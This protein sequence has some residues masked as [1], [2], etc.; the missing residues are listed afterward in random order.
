M[1][2]F[3]DKNKW[4]FSKSGDLNR[5][6]NPEPGEYFLG[7]TGDVVDVLSSSSPSINLFV[8]GVVTDISKNR[9]GDKYSSIIDF[10]SSTSEFF[11][12]DIFSLM[13]SKSFMTKVAIGSVY[14]VSS[15]SKF[16]ENPDIDTTSDPEDVWSF[17][18]VYN[19]SITDDID[20]IS[21]SS[22]LDE[23][24]V[25]VEGLDISGYEVVQTVSL[26]GQNR[27]ALNSPLSMVHRAFILGANPTVGDVY[28]YVDTPLT[29]GVPTDIT[30]IRAHVSN[31]SLQTEMVVYR[32]P[33]G[34]TLI[35]NEGFVA[36][37]RGVD[38]NAEMTLKIREPG[39][40]FRVKRRVSVNSGGSSHWRAV[41]S[42]P[43]VVRE[44]SDIKFTCENV[45]ANNT[46]VSGGF[47]A[48][49]IDNDFWNIG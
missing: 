34:K 27:V 26:S 36:I 20:S 4:V 2:F 1:Y 7:V 19:Y 23:M 37:S 47:E 9:S 25:Q 33:K 32:V 48:I 46:G 43:K 10:I 38:G 29:L 16:G 45:S 14:G 30:K 6:V 5:E 35:Y 28:I 3:K 17:G 31:S 15:L 24:S 49:L 18:G 11:V 42:I 39:G 41:Y 21:S 44:L 40:L 12:S 13:D 22:D 8:G